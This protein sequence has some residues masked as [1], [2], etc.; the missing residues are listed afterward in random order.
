MPGI[1]EIFNVS[2]SNKDRTINRNP[3]KRGL[4]TK[5]LFIICC[6]I[7][8]TFSVV[9]FAQATQYTFNMGAGSSVDTSGTN[10]V[11]QMF[12]VINNSG[13]D[14]EIFSLNAGETS[15]PIYF[16]TIGTTE[17]W[18]NDDDIIPGSITAHV[19]FDN[20][21]LTPAIGGTSLGFTGFFSFTQGWNLIWN[22][23]GTF[24]TPDGLEFSIDLTDVGYYSWL[25]QG[26]DGSADV[27][28]KITLI[29]EPGDD[30]PSS[31]PDAGIM[32]LLGPSLIVFGLF[33][34]KKFNR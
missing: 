20:P 1:P 16:A 26:P 23:S 33:S 15:N 31:V 29:S 2:I 27:Y 17:T 22:D 19:D 18:I 11:L 13:L 10:S 9:Q 24:S 28:A 6:A 14:S 25:W 12:A 8:L 4:M 30:P 32:W 5:R 7:V 34:R 21:D 3:H